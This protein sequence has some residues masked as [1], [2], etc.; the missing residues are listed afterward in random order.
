MAVKKPGCVCHTIPLN[1]VFG[2]E[3]SLPIFMERL[4]RLTPGGFQLCQ[5]GEYF[6]LVQGSAAVDPFKQTRGCE[7]SMLPAPFHMCVDPEAEK[8]VNNRSGH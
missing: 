8:K 1:F 4:P 6:L 3:R 5:R 7:E 2:K